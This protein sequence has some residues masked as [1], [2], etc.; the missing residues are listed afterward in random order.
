V[1]A[2]VA[3]LFC[4]HGSLGGANEG[5]FKGSQYARLSFDAQRFRA[6]ECRRAYARIAD[7]GISAIVDGNGQVIA[8]E[9][10]TDDSKPLA[11]RV[12]IDRRFSLYV[13]LGD[14]LPVGCCVTVA[15]L[16]M[17]QIARK[18]TPQ[19]DSAIG[20]PFLQGATGMATDWIEA[21]LGYV[22]TELFAGSSYLFFRVLCRGKIQGRENLDRVLEEGCILAPNHSSYL[23][24]M[25]LGALFR[26]Q[27]RRRLIFLAKDRLFRHPLFGPV[28]RHEKCLR[29]T[30]DGEHVL[31]PL[32]VQHIKYLCVFPEGRRS[33]DGKLG[34]A[35]SGVVK[36][37]VKLGLPILPVG[38]KGFFK[39]WPPG[40]FP[41]PSPCTIAF[42][43]PRRLAVP[44]GTVLPPEIL[45]AE[46]AFIMQQIA[47]LMR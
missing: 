18:P 14:W 35:H 13:L 26:Y 17:R 9:E 3:E 8:S 39:A 20:E 24:W 16:S 46:T 2:R 40:G 21:P 42:G 11:A 36:L 27:Y 41:R 47:S 7:R 43:E 28:M 19:L 10:M 32:E 29:V 38:L 23:D 25:V 5:A 22:L 1:S 34:R 30:D 44:Q 4:I 45:E 37:A 33:R 12:P 31:S 6:I 15:V